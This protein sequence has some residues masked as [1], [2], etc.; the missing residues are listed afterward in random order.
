M[1]T[2]REQ[3]TIACVPA[4]FVILLILSTGLTSCSKQVEGLSA[5]E[6]LDLGEKYLLEMDYE[7]AVVQFTKLI[8]IEPKNPRGYTGLAEAYIGLGETEKAIDIL[9]KG[10]EEIP[11]NPDIQAMIDIL[12]APET[13]PEPTPEPA[14]TPTD[15]LLPKVDDVDTLNLKQYSYSNL[16]YSFDWTS[17]FW[18]D[19]D[20]LGGCDLLFDISGY[21]SEVSDVLIATWGESFSL[22][23]IH[24][25]AEFWPPIWKEEDLGIGDSF[26]GEVAVGFP[27]EL[28]ILG[29]NVNVLLLALDKNGN[30]I[31]Y[32]IIPVTIPAEID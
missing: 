22:E 4:F 20:A 2:N 32:V 13:M 17:D 30:A 19:Q 3:R 25:E 18:R 27:I 15:Q 12:T 26:D 8:E 31:G 7:Q 16:S 28:D 1:K 11:D 21:T 9:R 24:T 10:L 23:Q 5:S 6:L 29:T 14:S